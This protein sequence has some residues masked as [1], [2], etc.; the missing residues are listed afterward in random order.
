MP[1]RVLAYSPC[2]IRPS[3]YDLSVSTFSPDGRVFQ[4]EYAQKAVD[5]SGTVLGMCC[6]DG[7]LL[8]AE[9]LEISK[10]LEENSNRRTFPI[11]KHAGAVVAGVS[12]DGRAIVDRAQGEASNYK[13]MYG[14]AIPG[15]VLADR[16]ASYVHVFNLYW[17]V[18]PFGVCTM[19]ASYDHNGPQ[20]FMIDPAGTSHKYYGVAVGKGRQGAKN[21]LSKLKLA[22]MTVKEAMF[23]AAK[24]MHQVHDGEKGFELELAIVSDETGRLFKRVGKAEL[25][26]VEAAAKAAIEAE[27][28]DMSD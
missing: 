23:A 6:K 5:S 14:D 13:S 25:Q 28:L 12:A 16:V 10:L 22:D 19:L 21:E 27:D 1:T 20:L 3:Q 2:I 11:D 24:I 17:Y 4:S 9:K 8:A 15:S 18:R 26:E 7:V